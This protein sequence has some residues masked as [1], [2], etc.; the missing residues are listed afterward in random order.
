MV[1]E[2]RYITTYLENN[3]PCD[4]CTMT[5][6]ITRVV[7]CLNGH[8]VCEECLKKQAKQTII[9]PDMVWKTHIVPTMLFYN[10]KYIFIARYYDICSAFKII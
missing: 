9:N 8:L 3:V 7:G 2:L 6:K 1:Y 10:Q 5:T 4:C